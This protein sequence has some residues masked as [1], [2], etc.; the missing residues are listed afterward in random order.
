LALLFPIFVD[1]EG[2]IDLFAEVGMEELKETLHSFQKDKISGPDG[3]T[4]EFYLGFFELLGLSSF[5]L[6]K[7]PGEM[8]DCMPL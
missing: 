2:N 6:L 1:E 5:R 3:W 4:I 8:G 7:N